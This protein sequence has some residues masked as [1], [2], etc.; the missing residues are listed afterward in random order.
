VDES[1]DNLYDSYLDA[2]ASGRAEGPEEF[3]RRHGVEDRDLLDALRSIHAQA[4]REAEANGVSRGVA[5]AD[6]KP[7]TD[8]SGLLGS[9]ARSADWIG[10]FDLIRKL[11]E[12]GMGVVWLATQQ[13]LGRVVAIKLLRADARMSAGAA[14]RL[15]REARAVA[16]LRHPGIVAIHAMGEAAGNVEGAAGSFAFIAMEHVEG[17]GLD[18]ILKESK[19]GGEGLAVARVLRWGVAL[20]RSLQAAHDL[21]IVHRDVKPSNVRIGA[22]DAPKLLDFGLARDVGSEQ[23]TISDAFVGSPFY[24]APEQVAR[25]GGEVDG[26]TDVYALG[27]VLYEALTGRSAAQ[28]QTLEQVLRSILVDEV[29]SPRVINARVSKDLGTVVMKALEKE[30]SRRYASA[31]KL[32]EDL[33]AILDLRAISARP[34]TAWERARRWTRR[35]RAMSAMLLTA[36]AAAVVMTG[37]LATRGAAEARARRDE[38]AR[39]IASAERGIERYNQLASQVMAAEQEFARIA[40]DRATRYFTDEQEAGF[41]ERSR[42]L[43]A[44]R[45]ERE[46]LFEAGQIDLARAERLGADAR[47]V[48]RARANWYVAIA[49]DAETRGDVKRREMFADLA[50]AHDVDGSIQDALVGTGSLTITS[51]PVGAD[52]YLFRRPL[53]DSRSGVDEPRRVLAAVRGAARGGGEFGLRVVRESGEVEA[54]AIIVSVAGF[55]VRDCVLVSASRDPRIARLDRVVSVDGRSIEGDYDIDAL[56]ETPAG[57]AR[58]V[59]LER[60]GVGTVEVVCE[61]VAGL[62]LKEPDD[63]VRE[64]GVPVAV[65]RDGGPVSATSGDGLDVR[66]TGLMTPLVETAWIGRTPVQDVP[67]EPGGYV[68]VLRREGRELTRI[69]NS[70]GRHAPTAWHVRLPAAGER[71]EGFVYVA[72]ADVWIMEREVTCREYFDFLNDPATLARFAAE[73]KPILYPRDGDSARGQKDASGRFVLPEGWR[74]E[75]PVLFVSWHDA[76]AYAAWRTERARRE[77]KAWTFGLPTLGEWV[78]AASGAPGD[79]FVFGPEFRPKWASSCFAR[80]RPDPEPVMRFAIDESVL[81][82]YDMAGSAS[83]WSEDVY[84]AGYAYRRYM[85]GAWGAGEAEHFAVYGGN[86][87]SPERVGGMIGFRLVMREGAGARGNVVDG[88]GEAAKPLE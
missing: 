41:G 14:E 5:A 25:R 15:T 72:T 48:Q 29:V 68:A 69:A 87:L 28:G 9:A 26:R 75:W 60:A 77:G 39:L 82:V 34:A 42:R 38:A 58:T 12:G 44:V 71:P 8:G 61:D 55:A 49:I 79:R 64:A 66:T 84:R 73:G 45:R 1:R 52:V 53:L 76:R 46:S 30:P 86:G 36:G 67:M 65:L 74:W 20:A 57:T 7:G 33:E 56:M 19:E 63:L 35:H 62:V 47:Q 16:K 10:E 88:A 51:D 4:T 32:A 11:G 70:V 43:D 13:S 50:R 23:A 37:V 83:E 81:G 6:R 17:R 24:A 78:K 18:E 27:A 54:G 3:L 21:G 22:D 80:P 31:A 85:G 59:K 2:A 40:E